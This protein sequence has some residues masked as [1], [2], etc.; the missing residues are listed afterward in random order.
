[1]AFFGLDEPAGGDGSA[2]PAWA[3]GVL[4]IQAQPGYKA[5]GLEVPEEQRL[6]H[7]LH[8]R[9]LLDLPDLGSVY[10]RNGMRKDHTLELF[11]NGALALRRQISSYFHQWGTRRQPITACISLQ[12]DKEGDSQGHAQNGR[13]GA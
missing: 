1:M 7:H 4:W 10:R 12:A 6:S 9:H 13:Q 5:L 11:G 8:T 3:E 2:Q